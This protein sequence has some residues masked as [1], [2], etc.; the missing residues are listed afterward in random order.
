MYVAGGG[1]AHGRR[2]MPKTAVGDHT[3]AYKIATLRGGPT[4]PAHLYLIARRDGSRSKSGGTSSHPPRSTTTTGRRVTHTGHQT[5]HAL[6][7]TRTD[8]SALVMPPPCV[9]VKG[10]PLR[11]ASLRDRL[12]RPLTRP[13]E[14][15]QCSIGR[16]AS[17]AVLDRQ[18]PRTVDPGSGGEQPQLLRRLHRCC[19]LTTSLARQLAVV[20]PGS[21]N[22]NPPAMRTTRLRART[23]LAESADRVRSS[24]TVWWARWHSNPRSRQRRGQATPQRPRPLSLACSCH[25]RRIRQRLSRFRPHDAL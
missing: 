15:A 24:R 10:A 22:S 8:T 5:A 17:P 12:L 9:R 16:R 3:V 18:P 4:R 21:G 19:V 13:R 25:R 20:P 14:A 6:G 1:W 23:S 11:S 2:V 7:R